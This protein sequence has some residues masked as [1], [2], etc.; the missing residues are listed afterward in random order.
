MR[1]HNTNPYHT[2]FTLVELMIVIAIIGVVASIA[3]PS[4]MSS[5]KSANESA[6]KGQFKSFCMAMECYYNE[7]TDMGYPKD[8]SQFG[9]YFTHMD[10]KNGYYYRYFA[11]ETA[12]DNADLIAYYAYP[13]NTGAGNR[14]FLV[15]ESC[16]MWQADISSA[17]QLCDPT[18]DFT[19]NGTQRVTRP[20]GLVWIQQN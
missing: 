15:D 8:T 9:T 7:Q 11:H 13:T 14:I 6:V 18:I 19:K 12:T 16:R 20:A 2:G 10:T 3:V 5:R 17:E 1:H 4:V